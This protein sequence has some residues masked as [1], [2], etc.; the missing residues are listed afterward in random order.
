M[1]FTIDIDTG[2][3]F[4]DGLFTSGTEIKRVKV[5]STPHDLTVSW[6]KCMEAGA[7][8]CGFSSLPDFLEQVDI[9]RWSNTVASNVVAERKGPKMGLFVT[10]GNRQSLYSANGGNPVLGHLIEQNH[11]EEIRHPIDTEKLLIKLKELLESGVRRICISLNDA[12][13]NKDE[14]TIKEIIEDQFPDHYLGHVPLLLGRDICKHPDDMTR[15]N[16]ALL[17]SYVHGP[18][19]QSMYKAE[20]ELRG[21]GFRKPLLL[22]HTDG[23]VVR[24]SK[25]KPVDTIES[26]P[27]FGIHAGDYWAN[28]YDFPCVITL[29]VGGTTTKVGLIKD[30]HPAMTR[31]PDLLGVPLKQAMLDL[32][33]I[34]IGGGT[35][36]R[37]SGG[38]LEMGPESMGAFPGPA[39][40]D[41]GGTEATLTDAC[42]ISG[43]L[44]AN[45]FAGGE[46]KIK[47]EQAEKVLKEKIAVPL[48]LNL[49][50]AANEIISKAADMIAAEI[51]ELANKTEKPALDFVLF[52]FGGNGAVLGCEVAQKAGIQKSYIFSLGA[53]LS[54]FGSSV[55]DITHT[56]EYSP[57]VPVS[58][59][60][61]LAGMAQEMLQEAQRDME[62]EGFDLAKLE[63]G[64]DFTLYDQRDPKNFIQFSSSSWKKADFEEKNINDLIRNSFV[65]A[66]KGSD[67]EDL[68]VEVMK[69]RARLPVAK[70]QPGKTQPGKENPSDAHKG[71]RVIRRGGDGISS[72]I[73]DWNKLAAGN[74]VAGPAVLEGS[75]T[76]YVVP[77]GWR[78]TMDSY[79]NGELERS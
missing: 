70:V 19:A 44:D 1:G 17:N 63:A 46:K 79:G 18:L 29:D 7:E 5:D 16:M 25:T 76:T 40:Y 62:G 66:G 48:G 31:D 35:V 42:L 51:T 14:V 12:L 11:V 73:Y 26:G 77:Q 10:E 68:I 4:I 50:D 24:V 75:D 47:R 8:Q 27:I 54:A 59:H 74:T 2:G 53:V 78:M 43:Y 55:A 36:A 41:L 64:L 37:V 22:G 39:C 9:V 71:E 3:T 6:L 45:Y 60:E 13:K 49:E 21:H 69:L 34:A 32:K 38:K 33:S 28:L 57:L 20:D 58:E 30:S 67:S 15:T 52:A 65:D 61:V 72:T 56:Y 23:G